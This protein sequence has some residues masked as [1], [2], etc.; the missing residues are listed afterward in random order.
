MAEGSD[1]EKTEPASQQKLDKAR[2]DGDV[3]RSR[4][5]GTCTLLIAAGGGLWAT[6]D[7]MVRSL[8]HMLVTGLTLERAHAMPRQDLMN[9]NSRLQ[10]QIP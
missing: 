10:A 6:G 7:N 9:R 3:P 4:E 2:E 8:N 1:L 5:L